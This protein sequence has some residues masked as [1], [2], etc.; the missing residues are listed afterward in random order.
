MLRLN[1]GL[2][3]SASRRISL[4]PLIDVVFILLVFFMLETSFRNEGG[5]EL[6]GAAGGGSPASARA[7]VVEVFDTHSIWLDGIRMPFVDW[8]Q[9][10][11]GISGPAELRSAPGIPIQHIVTTMDTLH[12]KGATT[13]RLGEARGFG[14]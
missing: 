10:D 9:A 4:T 11:G 3:Q 13:V 1:S 2:Y 14:Q 5:I 8:Q 6:S 12:D 7:L